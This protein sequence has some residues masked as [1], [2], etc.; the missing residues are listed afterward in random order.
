M[1]IRHRTTKK[2]LASDLDFCTRLDAFAFAMPVARQNGQLV[3]RPLPI[4]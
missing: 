1:V 3:M 4:P 2:G